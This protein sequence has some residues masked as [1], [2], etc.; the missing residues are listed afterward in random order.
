MII[1]LDKKQDFSHATHVL[2][3]KF[4]ESISV[5][6]L[7]DLEKIKEAE[8]AKV[9]VHTSKES[10]KQAYRFPDAY[11][12]MLVKKNPFSEEELKN[13]ALN[14]SITDINLQALIN[15]IEKGVNYFQFTKPAERVIKPAVIPPQVPEKVTVLSYEK[16]TNELCNLLN[17][18]NK[19]YTKQECRTILGEMHSNKPYGLSRNYIDQAYI[20]Y[21]TMLRSFGKTLKSWDGHKPIEPSDHEFVNVISQSPSTDQQIVASNTA[22]KQQAAAQVMQTPAINQDKKAFQVTG[23]TTDNKVQVDGLTNNHIV[24]TS[25]ATIKMLQ[26]M[27]RFATNKSFD[28]LILGENGAGKE[29]VIKTLLD[30]STGGKNLIVNVGAE[31][32]QT[33]RSTLFGHKKGSF[34]GADEDTPGYMRSCQGG[35]LVFDEVGDISLQNQQTALRAI[36]ARTGIAL[37]DTKEFTFTGSFIFATNKNL[38]QMVKEGT[39]R[40]DFYNRINT[41]VVVIPPLRERKQDIP[42]L[43]GH[44]VDKINEKAKTKKLIKPE[45]CDYLKNFDW[46]GNVRELEKTITRAHFF[47]DENEIGIQNIKE[48]I[49]AVDYEPAKDVKRNIDVIKILDKVAVSEKE[50]DQPDGETLYTIEQI[51]KP[52]MRL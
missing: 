52:Q 33:F 13:N 41:L 39:M 50:S 5:S 22:T 47:S 19:F 20:Y 6:Q 15:T 40:E 30:N 10:I 7:D 25:E 2:K 38:A 17:G 49:M 23:V 24:G 1:L 36:Q 9:I 11:H 27:A 26:N 37:G 4:K 31:S 51:R 18:S 32:D 29:M 12:I 48:A 42:L 3:G 8:N 21:D 14:A 45:A 34:T 44:F 43:A 28:V 16:T 35:R 46:P